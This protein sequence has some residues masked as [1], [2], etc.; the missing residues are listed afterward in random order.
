MKSERWVLKNKKADFQALT[1]KFNI[2]EVLAR[3]L[4]NRDLIEEKEIN[5][6]LEPDLKYLHNP[7]LMKDLEKACNIL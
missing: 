3:L 7:L 2:S 4:T 5:I 6:F 1:S